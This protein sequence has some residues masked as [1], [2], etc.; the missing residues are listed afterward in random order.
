MMYF[1]IFLILIGFVG[2]AFAE[3]LFFDNYEKSQTVLVGK[4]LSHQQ[5]HNEIVYEIQVEAYYK[6]PQSAK[7]VAVFDKLAEGNDPYRFDVNDRLFLYVNKRD[8]VYVMHNDSFKL[9]YDCDA[10][11]LIPPNLGTFYRGT[12]V[13]E[14][15]KF[16][17]ADAYGNIYKIG[18]N[19]QIR[20]TVYNFNP[21]LENATVT[22][23]IN[24]TNQN[25]TVF[26]DQKNVIVPACNGVVPIEWSFIPVQSDN[27]VA[28]IT[29]LFQYNTSTFVAEFVSPWVENGFSARENVGCCSIEKTVY[30]VP[31]ESTSQIESIDNTW[32]YVS[33]PFD[34]HPTSSEKIIFHDIEFSRPYVYDPPRHIYSDVMFSDGT[35]ETLSVLLDKPDFSDHVNPQA[36]LVQ[37]ITGYYFL[38]S[39]NLKE[40]SP[41]KQFKSGIPLNE[42]KCKEGLDLAVKKNNRHP[43]CITNESKTKLEH[44][45]FLWPSWIGASGEEVSESGAP[46][47]FSF[48]YSFGISGKNV[49]DSAQNHFLADMVCDP[50]IGITINLSDTEKQAIWQSVLQNDFFSFGNFTQN[51]DESGQCLSISPEEF[52]TLS[53]TGNGKTH[54][55]QHRGSYLYNDNENYLKFEEIT[56]IINNILRSRDNFENLPSPRCAYQ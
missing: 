1:A 36:G 25:K 37:R 49:L 7:V 40:L 45:G 6:N 32:Y 4:V 29:V 27:Y 46:F 11:G 44:M 5:R 30:P 16:S 38:V 28:R 31:W 15:P 8:G 24:G 13:G 33:E 20:Y 35:K 43:I 2:T 39:V 53:V 21:L 26:S 17:G 51:C 42:I 10:G 3:N 14:Y 23:I 12:P 22:L 50:P 56:E 18:K 54:T 41:L 48:V 52:T 55:I 19:M 34:I 9:D 47:D